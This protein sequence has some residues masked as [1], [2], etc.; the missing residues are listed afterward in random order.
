LVKLN[1]FEVELATHFEQ[2]GLEVSLCPAHFEEWHTTQ[3]RTPS[4]IAPTPGS[5]AHL[6]NLVISDML[7]CHDNPLL[8]S[9][10][11]TE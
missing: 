3:T 5:S 2:N 9:A 4:K 1:K 8:L 11:C 7:L 6:L 10:G